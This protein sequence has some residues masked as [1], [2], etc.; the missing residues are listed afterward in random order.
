MNLE[1]EL[2]RLNHA[3]D[4]A[5]QGIEPQQNT[6][7]EMNLIVCEF[8][9]SHGSFMQSVSYLT[10]M[11]RMRTITLYPRCL[12]EQKLLILNQIAEL[13]KVQREK[14]VKLLLAHADIPKRFEHAS[15]DNFNPINTQAEKKLKVCRAYVDKWPD[16]LSKGG[17]IV[18]M[19]QPGMGKNHLATAIAKTIIHKYCHSVVMTS[20]LKIVRDYRS[21]WKKTANNVEYDV[22]DHFTRPKLLIID[23]VGVQYGT[24]TE[25]LILFEIINHRYKAMKPTILISNETREMLVKYIDD[26]VMDRMREGG[27]CEL[28]F[29]WESYRTKV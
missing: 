27:G 28:N 15:F 7:V 10:N 11:P 21:S 19:G 17:G 3:I 13:K 2:V 18:M 22:I 16:R 29:D 6:T 8:N 25:K 24:E 9:A 1:Q 14:R 5:K 4:M 12:D 20:V 23:G 26:R